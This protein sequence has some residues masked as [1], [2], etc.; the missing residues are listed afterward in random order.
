MERPPVDTPPT[1][2]QQAQ[3]YTYSQHNKAKSRVQKDPSNHKVWKYLTAFLAYL[4]YKH[5]TKKFSSKIFCCYDQP[6]D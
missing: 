4:G 6:L 3:V 5:F 2:P 1:L